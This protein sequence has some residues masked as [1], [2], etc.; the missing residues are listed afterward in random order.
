MIKKKEKKKKEKKRKK[1]PTHR[2]CTTLAFE[3]KCRDVLCQT[4]P[5]DL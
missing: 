1:Q 4:L 2:D 5:L 3:V